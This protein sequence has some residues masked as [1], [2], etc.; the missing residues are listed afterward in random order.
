MKEVRDIYTK[1]NTALLKELEGTKW[2]DIL[3]LMDWKND[4]SMPFLREHGLLLK[5]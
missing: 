4:V 5:G 3:M 1:I 2:R